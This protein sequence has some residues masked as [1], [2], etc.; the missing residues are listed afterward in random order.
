MAPIKAYPETDNDVLDPHLRTC[1]SFQ[2]VGFNCVS[3]HCV[4]F[5][6]CTY[7]VH[8]F[9]EQA[10]QC[11]S[12]SVALLYD[13]LSPFVSGARRVCHQGGATDDALESFLKRW[14]TANFVV[15]EWIHDDL[16]LRNATEVMKDIVHG[17]EN[18]NDRKIKPTLERRC[19]TNADVSTRV[20]GSCSHINTHATNA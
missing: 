7:I 18:Q 3:F 19:E 8:V 16:T 6:R 10:L 2:C 13:A 17:S 14:P 4:G 9:R 1:V 11:L 20:Y 5:K 12:H 15:V